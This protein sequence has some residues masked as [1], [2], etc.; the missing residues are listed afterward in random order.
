MTMI[1]NN[2]RERSRFM[3]FAL[4]GVVGAIVDFGTFN[5]IT[6]LTPI[7]AV[8]AQGFSFTAAIIS[9]F[10]WNRYWTYP[11]SR[12]KAVPH[13]I[14]Q[15][16]V[17]SVIGLAIR[18]PLF[19]VLENPLGQLFQNLNLPVLNNFNPVFL[20]HNAALAFAIIVVMFWNFFVNRYWT[21][22]DVD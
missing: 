8:L 20:G 22:S 4:V 10:L 17:V 11:D 7:P 16:G 14:I 1:L 15:F 21:Y 13:Q 19:A 18:T 3:R 2:P 12:S 9:N 5:L 6:H